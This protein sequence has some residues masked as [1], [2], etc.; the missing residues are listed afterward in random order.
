[1][2]CPSALVVTLALVSLTGCQYDRWAHGFLTRQPAEKDVVGLYAVNQA[3][4]QRPIKL[5]MSG[6]V[7]RINPSAHILLSQDHE[8]DFFQVPEAIDDKLQCSVT[9]HGTWRLG[10]ND[11]FVEIWVQL[12]DEESDTRCSERF[13][14]FGEQLNLYGDKPPYLLHV[15]VGDPDSGDAVQFEHRN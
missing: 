7:L 2:N 9:G 12:A 13:S 14:K 5:A 4:L 15:T 8:A 11:R 1:M 10:K 3:S 6:S